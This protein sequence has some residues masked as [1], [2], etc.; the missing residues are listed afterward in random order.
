MAGPK[1]L[2]VALVSLSLPFIV[3]CALAS[4]YLGPVALTLVVLL[5][6][7]QGI[8]GVEALDQHH[9]AVPWL[10]LLWAASII[11]ALGVGSRNYH[12]IY[13]PYLLASQGRSRIVPGNASASGF[14]DAGA[15]TFDDSFVL[16]GARAVGFRAFGQ[17]YCAAPVVSTSAPEAMGDYP[18][19]QF[20]AV[21]QDCCAAREHFMC[22]D[23]GE[24][25][26]HGGVV[27][28]DP[29]ESATLMGELLAPRMFDKGWSRAIEASCALHEMQSAREPVL[30]T[31]T[32]NPEGVLSW[33]HTM[34]ILVWLISSAVHLVIVVICWTAISVSF[35]A[36][37]QKAPPPGRQRLPP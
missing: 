21:G 28:H 24:E 34:A 7:L 20:W 11:S 1:T 17:T 27:L 14:K 12:R 25:D 33:W 8:V 2:L 37:N 10:L 35:P 23:A 26:V 30:L 13:S 5:V 22:D 36:K 9:K 31:W 15:L 3:V 29:S 19:V 16:D 18:V 6:L 32:K 4:F